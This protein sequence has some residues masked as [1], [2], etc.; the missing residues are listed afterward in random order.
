MTETADQTT[1][2]TPTR[3]SAAGKVFLDGVKTI[4]GLAV[5]LVFFLGSTLVILAYGFTGTS[6]D[7]RA[8]L[9]WALIV[10]MVGT[11]I[12]VVL[13]GLWRPSALGGPPVPGTEDVTFKDSEIL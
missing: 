11:F 1:S 10:L 5:M 8:D 7:L 13:L 6:G 12:V 4:L 9:I 2:D 3:I